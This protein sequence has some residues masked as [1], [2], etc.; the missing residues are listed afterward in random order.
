M[1]FYINQ[2]MK[3]FENVDIEFFD[4]ADA[5]IRPDAGEEVLIVLKDSSSAQRSYYNRPVTP[6]GEQKLTY[7]TF[8]KY[9]T[10]LSKFIDSTGYYSCTYNLDDIIC[11]GRLKKN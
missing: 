2:R 1:Y 4:M 6:T 11:W 3:V 10:V 5:R 7:A 8:K 9:K